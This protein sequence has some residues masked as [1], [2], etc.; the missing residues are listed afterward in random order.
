MFTINNSKPGNPLFYDEPIFLDNKII[1]ETT[2]G[3]YS[4]KYDN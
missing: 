4:F 2:S 1:G 3:N